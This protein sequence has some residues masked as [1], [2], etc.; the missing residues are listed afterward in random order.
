MYTNVYRSGDYSMLFQKYKGRKPSGY[1]KRKTVLYHP[2]T[3][4]TISLADGH[5]FFRRSRSSIY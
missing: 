1:K 2:H 3:A 5:E 4:A